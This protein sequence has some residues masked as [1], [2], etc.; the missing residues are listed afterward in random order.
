M[1]SYNQEDNEDTVCT[2]ISNLITNAYDEYGEIYL[3]AEGIQAYIPNISEMTDFQKYALASSIA[4]CVILFFYAVYLYRTISQ[5]RFSWAPRSR[6]G[7]SNDPR[8]AASSMGRMHSG[9]IQG[10]SRS[11]NDFELHGGLMA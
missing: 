9:I 8:T 3:E 6:R 2:F 4:A 1:Q 10:R 11:G 5:H 7:Y